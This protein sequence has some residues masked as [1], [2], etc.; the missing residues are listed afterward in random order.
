MLTSPSALGVGESI[1]YWDGSGSVSWSA[2]QNSEYFD[3]QGNTSGGI[4]TGSTVLSGVDL[5]STNSIG[6]FDTHP[7]FT[8]YGN[9]GTTDPTVGFYA[10]FARTNIEGLTSS[11]KWA[12]VFGYGLED[13]EA[14]EAAVDSLASVVPEPGTAIL[15][16]LGL[17]GLAASGRRRQS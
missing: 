7:D 1:L 3:I 11:N 5:D 6:G 4:L 15:M 16:G 17:A 14:H 12:V 13:E 2:V 10:L 8:L 9:G